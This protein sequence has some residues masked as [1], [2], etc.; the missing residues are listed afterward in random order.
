MKKMIVPVATTLLLLSTSGFASDKTEFNTNSVNTANEE[1]ELSTQVE[2]LNVKTKELQKEITSLHKQV[3]IKKSKKKAIAQKDS[4][5]ATTEESPM[6][7][8][9]WEHYVTVTT[10]PYLSRH[11]SYNGSDL[12]YNMSSIN[13]DLILLKQKQKFMTLMNDAGHPLNEPMLQF[14]GSLAGQFYSSG[15]FTPASAG[16]NVTSGVTLSTAEIDMNAM[17]SRWATGFMALTFSG[18]PISAGN[19]NPNAQIFL[20]R[21]FVTIGDLNT[22]PM[23]LTVGEMYSPFGV[24]TSSMVS[25]PMTQSMMEIRTPTAI[26]GYTHND[27]FASI[28]T[29][30][31][32]QQSGGDVIFKQ[33]GVD[34]G[35]RYLFNGNAENKLSV[36]AGWVSNVTDS[37]GMQGTGYSTSAGQFAGF[38]VTPA[39]NNLVHPVRGVDVNAAF[40]WNRFTLLSEYMIATQRFAAAD[41]SFNNVGAPLSPAEPA[42]LHAE[43]NYKLPFVPKKYNTELGVSFDRTWQSLAL[44]L[45]QNKY[46]MF[47]NTNLFRETVESIE[48]NYQTDYSSNITASGEGATAPIVGTGRGVNT[49]ILQVG[50]YF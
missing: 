38:G 1:A 35:Y 14:S 6:I 39:A 34:T 16:N 48:Y 12:L 18:S 31:G 36:G 9:L 19:R 17:A 23:Y 22:F 28:F 32:S 24:Y 46:A 47:L 41:L 25:T 44:N 5:V 21:G 27:F 2:Q 7:A 29:Y 43:V 45:E 3:A 20:Q 10:A 49:V 40:K 50:M 11:S 15:A 26:V 13:E 8:K 33:W 37:Q 4:A 42:A 30:S